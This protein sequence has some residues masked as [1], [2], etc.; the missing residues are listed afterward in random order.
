[1]DH[2]KWV[3]EHVEDIVGLLFKYILLLQNSGVMKWIFDEVIRTSS[4]TYKLF[5]VVIKYFFIGEELPSSSISIGILCIKQLNF[6]K[7][8]IDLYLMGKR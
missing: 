3:T 6:L 1:M 2:L 4:S 5:C 7:W 8:I